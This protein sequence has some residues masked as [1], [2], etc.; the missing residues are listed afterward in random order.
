MSEDATTP[1]EAVRKVCDEIIDLLDRQLVP[2]G[3]LAR[4]LTD[5]ID[6]S[7]VGHL[8]EDDLAGLLPTI[9]TDL[10]S[11]PMFAGCGFAAA[12]GVIEAKDHYLLWLQK[13]PGGIHRL[14][15]NLNPS[16]PDLYDYHDT[17]WFSGAQARQAPA[18]YGPY[19]DYAGANLLA[20]TVAVPVVVEEKFIGVAGADLY[21]EAVES[22]LIQLMRGL[23]DAVVV[24]ADRSVVA[25][26]SARWMPGERVGVHPASDP[27]S[28]AAVVPLGDWAGWVLAL[29]SSHS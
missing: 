25:S 12:P 28:Y 10:E 26:G 9:E 3:A 8:V 19:I 14:N 23:P 1:D 18:V 4:S 21:A 7:G 2:I 24:N 13:G 17:D 20:L 6:V 22:E 27:S 5:S 16:D 15:L 29:A 11:M